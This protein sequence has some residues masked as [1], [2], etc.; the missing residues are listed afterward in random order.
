MRLVF[1]AISWPLPRRFSQL[2]RKLPTTNQSLLVAWK[3]PTHG[4]VKLNTDGAS[5][6]N[7]GIS[8]AGGINRSDTGEWILGFSAHLGVCSSITAELQEIRLGLAIA[9]EYSFRNVDCDVDARLAPNLIESEELE[10]YD[11]PPVDVLPAL[12][13]D[14]MGIAFQRGHMTT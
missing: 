7:P 1:G 8:G 9:W 14:L 3:A 13:A 12:K 4:R 2:T 10:I 5:R 6:W 11:H